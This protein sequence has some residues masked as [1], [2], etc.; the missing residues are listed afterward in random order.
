MATAT[1]TATSTW[2]PTWTPT[3]SPS[4]TETQ[5]AAPTL[6]PLPP[7]GGGG[8]GIGN[9][10]SFSITLY[11]EAGEAVKVLA[12]DEP[13]GLTLG[14]FTVQ[15]PAF[16][17]QSGQQ[18]LIIV[19][20]QTYLWN[21]SNDNGQQVSSGLYWVKLSYR[22]NYGNVT[23]YIHE[24]VVLAVGNQV[25]VRIFNSAGEQVRLLAAYAYGDQ[26]Q[27]TRLVPDSSSIAFGP[28][29]GPLNK[30]T[31]DLGGLSV[32][33]D[34]LN[35]LGQR[36]NSGQYTVQ[37]QSGSMGDAPVI[38]TTSITVLNA[39]GS[40]LTGALVG[41]NPLGSDQNVVQVRMPGAPVGTLVTGR[42]YNVAGE[43]IMSAA[44]DMQP[45]RMSFDLGGRNIAGGIY[46]VAVTAKAPWGQVERRT[47]KLVVVR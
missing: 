32:E 3:A 10:T 20:G 6:T 27:P 1:P 44:N 7:G 43:L 22:D 25:L 4:P 18:A 41:P 13:A 35:D 26:Q 16:A 34:G 39:D 37:L 29:G 21:G 28:D 12:L 42:L 5:T 45:D 8:D 24:V 36:V 47:F 23:A 46:L 38:A 11:N 40:V 15:N 9:G 31:F 17:P 30:L 33:W 2:T 14:D 19:D